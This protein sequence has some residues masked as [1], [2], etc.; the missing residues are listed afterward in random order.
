MTQASATKILNS[1]RR[2]LIIKLR[3]HG[4]MLLTTPVINTLHQ[5]YPDAEIDM[6]VYLE[7]RDMLASH[8]ALNQ[9]FTIDRQWKKQGARAHMGHEVKLARQ[10]MKRKYDLVVNLA[11]QWRSAIVTRLT[12]SPVRLGFAFPKRRGKVWPFCHTQ[13]VS[14]SNHGKQHTVEQNLSIL[15][16]LNIV[17]PVSQAT[18]SYSEQDEQ[19]VNAL[20][21]DNGIKI[22]FIV[23]QPTSR[24][25]FKCWTEEKMA[26]TFSALSAKGFPIVV[27]AGPDKRELEMVANILTLCPEANVTSLAGKLTLRQLAALIDK[28]ALFIGVDSVPMHMA[29][30]LQTP[31]IALFGPSK[32]TFWKPWQAQGEVIW[33]GDFGPLPDPD[34]IDTHTS[35][36][37]LDAIPTQ[38]V[39]DAAERLLP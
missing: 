30:A 11:D 20:L 36:R 4:D 29:A 14:T 19:A 37:Y 18:M 25:F 28:A 3:H 15:E 32:L 26:A 24:W 9:L 27:T 17:S 34:D 6:L 1:P 35:E 5:H 16:P 8:P 2:I 38:A 21:H 23:V 10:L 13:L 39:I 33:A 12:G 22:P 31:L 7:T